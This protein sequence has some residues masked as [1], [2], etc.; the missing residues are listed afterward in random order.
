M[1]R[2]WS[3]PQASLLASRTKPPQLKVGGSH[4]VSILVFP[5]LLPTLNI[6]ALGGVVEVPLQA[7]PACSEWHALCSFLTSLHRMISFARI[8][9]TSG[10]STSWRSKHQQIQAIVGFHIEWVPPASDL[11]PGTTGG[12]PLQTHIAECTISPSFYIKSLCLALVS[13][14]PHDPVRR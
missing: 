4:T 2:S 3:H 9:K 12:S 14:I 10:R 11:S 1:T 8:G 6:K 7:S 5:P 13:D